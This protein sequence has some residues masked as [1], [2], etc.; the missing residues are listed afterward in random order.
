L[1][2]L[3]E[4]QRR[5][6]AR[7]PRFKYV[8]TDLAERN[9]AFWQAHPALKPFVEQGVLDFARFD[10]EHDRA[11]TLTRSG[12]VLAEGTVKNPMVVLGNYFFDSIP[13][14]VFLLEEGQLRECAISLFSPQPEPDLT[15]PELLSRIQF[16]YEPRPAA[17]DYYPEPELNGLLRKYQNRVDRAVLL[18]PIAGLRC[19][20]LLRRISGGRLL[21]LSADKGSV[22]ELSILSQQVPM[23]SIHGSF[24]MEVNFHALGEYFRGHGGQVLRTT[25]PLANLCV[26]AF[27]MGPHPEGYPETSLAFAD[28]IERFGPD[29]FFSVR[30]AIE[31]S[32]GTLSLE[33]ILAWLRLCRADPYTLNQCLPVL[34]E[35]APSA[36]LREQAAILQAI[37]LAWEMYYHVGGEPNLPFGLGRLLSAMGNFPEAL[38]Y[39]QRAEE[40][41]GP[42]PDTLFH[43]GMCHQLLQQQKA[44]LRCFE[45]TLELQ[46]QH[47]GAKAMRQALLG[48]ASPGA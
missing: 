2:R 46:P 28:R 34:M 43:M 38:R 13:Q 35:R 36:S 30:K 47:E 44:A 14:D 45:R 42:E 8:L 19:C 15:D 32:Y 10:A 16:R 33:Q 41:F 12:E 20:Q 1:R 29:E 24:S 6:G 21:L 22:D 9:V 17:A 23:L 5:F 26:V 31:K 40:L 37:R 39:Y 3:Q 25:S 48:A 18:F 4:L 7:V 27:L 11:V